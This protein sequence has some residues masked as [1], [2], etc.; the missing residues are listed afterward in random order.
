MLPQKAYMKGKMSPSRSLRD[1]EYPLDWSAIT[2]YVGFPAILKPADG[3]GWKNVHRV[4]TLEELMHVYDTTN[5]LVM[6]LQQIHRLRRGCRYAASAS[7]ESLSCPSSTTRRGVAT[8]ST[9][10]GWS[11]RSSRSRGA[12]AL[13]H[14][15]SYDMNSVE[16]RVQG[17]CL[18]HGLSRTQA[19]TSTYTQSCPST[20]RIHHERDDALLHQVCTR[21]ARACRRLRV[22]PSVH[23]GADQSSHRVS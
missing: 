17:A 9:M 2:R 21:G 11:R 14:A 19:P 20:L 7:G 16:L 23:E 4:N 10:A 13:N 6:T 5:E 8:S 3:G 15:L 18:R 22:S 1:L 12:Y